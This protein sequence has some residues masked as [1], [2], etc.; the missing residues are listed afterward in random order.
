MLHKKKKNESLLQQELNCAKQATLKVFYDTLHAEMKAKGFSKTILK[1]GVKVK[2]PTAEYNLEGNYTPNEVL[3][4][5]M[6]AA[7]KVK[8]EF[9]VLVTETTVQRESYNLN[10]EILFRFP[11][12][13]LSRPIP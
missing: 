4:K 7:E 1:D 13:L 12:S 11:N 6:E 10:P 9:S 8:L 5:A 2:L 3:L